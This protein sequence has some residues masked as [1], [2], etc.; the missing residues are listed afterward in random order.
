[1]FDSLAFEA[2]FLPFIDEAAG[3]DDATTGWYAELVAIPPDS[4]DGDDGVEAPV[5]PKAEGGPETGRAS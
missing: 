2:D 3:L 1:M 5:L 4:P